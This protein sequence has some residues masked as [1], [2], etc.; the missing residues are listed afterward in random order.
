MRSNMALR[1]LRISILVSLGHGGRGVAKRSTAGALAV[2]PPPYRQVG[3]ANSASRET[4]AD[5]PR[6]GH[7]YRHAFHADLPPTAENGSPHR[8]HTM[9][10]FF[11]AASDP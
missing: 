4:D 10:A 3:G 2:L 8:A 9:C 11:A 6:A 5:L 1:D 7:G